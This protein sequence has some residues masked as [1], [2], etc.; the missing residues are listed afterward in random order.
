MISIPLIR[1]R[2]TPFSVTERCS[3]VVARSAIV[4]SSR[5]SDLSPCA[6]ILPILVC[7]RHFLAVGIDVI[8]PSGAELE[9]IVVGSGIVG[10]GRPK[11][12]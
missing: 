5:E 12:E 8:S 10:R 4:V 7:H 2:K 9:R 6:S 1:W 3:V 11:G